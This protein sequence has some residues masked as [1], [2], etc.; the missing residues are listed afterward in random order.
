MGAEEDLEE[1]YFTC[2]WAA[3]KGSAATNGGWLH[4]P[5][6]NYSAEAEY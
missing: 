3:E 1:E 5:L 6:F 4:F 2:G